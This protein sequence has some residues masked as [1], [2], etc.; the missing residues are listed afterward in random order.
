[1]RKKYDTDEMRLHLEVSL[2]NWLQIFRLYRN[3][4]L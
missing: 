1:M 3:S 2:Y 4:K